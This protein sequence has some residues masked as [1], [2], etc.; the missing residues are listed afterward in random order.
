MNHAKLYAFVLCSLAL[1]SVSRPTPA[2]L[3]GLEALNSAIGVKGASE[4]RKSYYSR[5]C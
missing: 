3:E 1:L 2:P 4:P 5:E